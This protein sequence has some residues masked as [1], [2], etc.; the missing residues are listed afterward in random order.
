MTPGAYRIFETSVFAHDLESL[1]ASVREKLEQKL[2]NFVYPQL[3][4]RPHFGPN[5]KKL[6]NWEPETWRYRIGSWRFFYEINEKD[7]VVYMT[8]LDP[9]KDAYS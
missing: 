4:N 5:I 6:R 3:K 8:T 9:R 1:D 7:K 2:R